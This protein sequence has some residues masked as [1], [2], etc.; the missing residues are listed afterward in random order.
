MT[1]GRREKD[2]RAGG[3]D[4]SWYTA[5]RFLIGTAISAYGDWLTTVALVVEL[6]RLTGSAA[7]PAGY[8]VARVAVRLIGPFPG[9]VL[10]DR[11]SPAL[12]LASLSMVQVILVTALMVA[13]DNDSLWAIYALVAAAQ[14]AGSIARPCEGAL[15][16]QLVSATRL[17]R[18]NGL[19]SIATSSSMFVAPAIGAVLLGVVSPTALIGIDAASFLLAALL[20]ASVS[21]LTNRRPTA[22]TVPVGAFEGVRAMWDDMLLR[23]VLV[24]SFASGVAVTTASGVLVVAATDRFHASSSVGLLYAAVGIGGICGGAVAIRWA[25]AYLTRRIII[26]TGI[27]EIG[28]LFALAG[29]PSVA[30]AIALLAVSS[31]SGTLYQSWGNTCVQRQLPGELVGRA[32][33]GLTFTIFLGMLVGA[34]AGLALAPTLGWAVTVAVVSAVDIGVVLVGCRAGTTPRVGSRAAGGQVPPLGQSSSIDLRNPVARYH[35][36]V[37][38]GDHLGPRNPFAASLVAGS[39][40]AAPTCQSRRGPA[41]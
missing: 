13:V 38:S 30:V 36:A 40:P 26:G 2:I 10:A 16:P 31:A 17:V 9:G 19:F 32:F 4:E 20:F 6:Y 18:V 15:I 34:L 5:G 23:S 12:V 22:G 41:R 27:A 24:V 8:M 11:Y 3:R 7:A 1:A 14:L 25:P 29:A 39:I 33:A 35:A 37:S 28:C 21:H